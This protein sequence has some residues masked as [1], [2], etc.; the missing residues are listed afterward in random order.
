MAPP[1]PWVHWASIRVVHDRGW[2]T[3]AQV[4]LSTWLFRASSVMDAFWWMLLFD[5]DFQGPGWCGSVDWALAWEPKGRWLDSQSGHKPVLQAGSLVGAH[6]RQPYINVSLPLYLFPFPSLK[7]NKILK[8]K[9]RFSLLVI[10]SSW[11]IHMPLPQ[12]S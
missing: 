9:K 5:K 6:E 2:L 7:I 1:P 4:I 11:S 10:F 12:T 3:S 8:K